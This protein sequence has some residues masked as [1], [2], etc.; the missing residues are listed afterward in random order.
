MSST[1]IIN[2]ARPLAEV[3]HDV[4][5]S[6]VEYFAHRTAGRLKLQ[7]PSLPAKPLEIEVP[8]QRC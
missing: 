2:A 5:C 6:I 3:I 7:I 4:D 8:S 1:I